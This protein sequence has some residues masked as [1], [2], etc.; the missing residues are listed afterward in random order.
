MKSPMNRRPQDLFASLTDEAYASDYPPA[1]ERTDIAPRWW[2]SSVLVSAVMTL[3][4][5][6]ALTS[7]NL[8]APAQR[9]QQNEL[10]TRVAALKQQVTLS[11]QEN[12]RERAALTSLAAAQL[13][14]STQGR[15]LLAEVAAAEVSAGATAVSDAGVCIAISATAR[16]SANVS[17]RDL[18]QLI[19][20][21]WRRG[22]RVISINDIRLTARS[23]IR[24]AGSAILVSYRPLDWPYR[25]CAVGSTAS[26]PTLSVPALAGV[27]N[28]FDRAHGVKSQ[29]RALW[30]VAPAAKLD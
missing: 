29:A 10:A 16:G 30:V 28:T 14:N 1:A 15:K 17:D 22:A 6:A 27:L 3:L 24:T 4:I 7:T 21:L 11:V 23:A 20:E 5:T 19:N 18:Q 2:T 12:T 13:S 25:V 9:A 26:R 8:L